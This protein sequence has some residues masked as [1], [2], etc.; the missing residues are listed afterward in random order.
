MGINKKG[1]HKQDDGSIKLLLTTLDPETLAETGTKELYTIHEKNVS[2]FETDGVIA[3]N[4]LSLVMSPNQKELLVTQSGNTSEIFTCIINSNNEVVK[5]KVTVVKNGFE[6]LTIQNGFV[7]NE[8][9]KCLSYTYTINKIYKRGVLVLNKKGAEAFMD[10]D[11]GSKMWESN[12]L[13]FHMSKDNSTLYVYAN[14]YGDYMD[15]GVLLSTVNLQQ[16]KYGPVQFFAYADDIK[17]KLYKMGFG[18]KAKDKYTV[19][20]VDYACTEL[21]N[22]TLALTGYPS[23]T[24]S[25]M[26]MKPT[27]INTNTIPA[28]GSNMTRYQTVDITMAGPIINVF[29]KDG[30][31]KFG[32]LYRKQ[33]DTE[34][35]GYIPIAYKDK[36]V[37]IYCDSKKNLEAG[38]DE[39][40]KGKD[41]PS[42]MV[43]VKAV[44]AANGTVISREQIADTP[45][46][47]N[48]YYLDYNKQLTN[49]SYLIPIGRLRLNMARYYTEIVQWANVEVK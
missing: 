46:G 3:R 39:K 30:Q 49:I 47:S 32:L 15:E 44:I 33:P 13:S 14:Y 4:Q 5:P 21:D 36:L 25:S 27:I 35:S 18:V 7:D 17:E 11:T 40:V 10:F 41:R 22:G 9:N 28:S 1:R 31:S 8:E 29:L 16:L 45:F 23:V 2:S 12:K 34:T 6:D 26:R 37:C 42:D 20:R 38:Q 19:K 43:L 48:Y 24:S